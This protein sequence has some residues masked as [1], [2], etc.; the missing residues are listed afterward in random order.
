MGSVTPR[1]E[2]LLQCLGTCAFEPLW[3]N[4]DFC[5]KEGRFGGVPTV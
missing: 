3:P 1:W 5:V 2:V 4:F